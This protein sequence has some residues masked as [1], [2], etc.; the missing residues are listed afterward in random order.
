M[1]DTKIA[2][3]FRVSVMALMPKQVDR[4]SWR[5]WARPHHRA[6]R[7]FRT[8]GGPKG[9]ELRRFG[10]QPSRA[11]ESVGQVYAEGNTI[12]CVVEFGQAA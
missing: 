7:A 8:R 11:S 6:T 2:A 1:S 4:E 12:E 5:L 9:V 10:D 3:S